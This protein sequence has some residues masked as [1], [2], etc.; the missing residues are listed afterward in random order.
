MIMVT[1]I[2]LISK[3]EF[4]VNIKNAV[5]LF[6]IGCES[7]CADRTIEGY[8]ANINMFL[9]WIQKDK[10]IVLEDCWVEQITTA[11][12]LDYMIYLRNRGIKN[13]SVASYLRPLRVFFNWCYD[14][15]YLKKRIFEK[16]K[17]PRNDKETILPLY[18]HEVDRIDSCF[19]RKTVYGLRNL[20]IVHLML[21]AGLRSSE[22]IHLKCSDILLDK[23]LMYVYGKGSKYRI[24]LLCPRLKSMICKYMVMVHDVDLTEQLPP[25]PLLYQKDSQ[26]PLTSKT[27]IQL[28]SRL[29]KQSGIDRVHAHLC[30]HTF[31]TSYIM[32]G[33]NLELLRMFLGH[34]DYSI[35]KEYMHIANQ[36]LL[37]DADIYRLD[38]VFFKSLYRE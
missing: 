17:L 30:R 38:K 1:F 31:A 13:T 10:G 33:G 35:T 25:E 32:G 2:L 6:L 19:D 4:F 23:N 26:E 28:F 15:D 14:E 27:I 20:L 16:V 3:G 21:D 5:S 29:K 11:M 7:S 9:N 34:Y 18:Q 36:F 8:Q 22:V 24:M 12:I 37:M